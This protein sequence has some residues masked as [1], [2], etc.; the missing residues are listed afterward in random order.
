MALGEQGG[1]RE[2]RGGGVG[3]WREE[4]AGGSR[5]LKVGGGEGNHVGTLLGQ[6]QLVLCGKG[7][8]RLLVLPRYHWKGGFTKGEGSS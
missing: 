2:R 4:G 6:R 8:Y 5:E 7:E 1:G 3:R